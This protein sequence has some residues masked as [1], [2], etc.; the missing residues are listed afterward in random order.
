MF[1]RNGKHPPCWFIRVASAHLQGARDNW[2]SR[3]AHCRA[4]ETIGNHV[5]Q[6]LQGAREGKAGIPTVLFSRRN[7][8]AAA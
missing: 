8:G 3:P 2:K 1:H 6:V 7:N 5:L 4:R